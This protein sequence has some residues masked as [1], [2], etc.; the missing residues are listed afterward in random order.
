LNGG[1][2]KIAISL[3][4]CQ[5]GGVTHYIS[6][7]VTGRVLAAD[8]HSPLANATVE[9]AGPDQKYEPSTL[10]KG[11]Q[12]QI[13]TGIVRTDASGRFELASKSVFALFRQPGWWSVPVTFS[14]YGYESFSTNYTGDNVTSHSTAGAPVVDAGN[15]LLT[16]VSK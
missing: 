6:P 7:E 13:Q 3:A 9:R 10:P 12:L 4:G 5:P 8:T 1:F 15:I 11:G 14:H 16:P 2:I